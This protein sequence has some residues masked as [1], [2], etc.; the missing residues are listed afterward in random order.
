[1]GRSTRSRAASRPAGASPNNAPGGVADPDQVVDPPLAGAAMATGAPQRS[2]AHSEPAQGPPQALDRQT[3]ALRGQGAG[4]PSTMPQLQPEMRWESSALPPCQAGDG[5]P[6]PAETAE[7]GF[8]Q[9]LGHAATA[10][11][12]RAGASA[13]LGNE[14]SRPMDDAVTGPSGFGAPWN[15]LFGYLHHKDTFFEL[16]VSRAATALS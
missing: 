5:F 14:T 7:K 6:G 4:L 8:D 3:S 15:T 11:H 12:S 1:M 16:R 9:G 10:T 13:S 2:L